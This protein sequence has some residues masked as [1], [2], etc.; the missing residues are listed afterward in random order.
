MLCKG[1]FPLK[2]GLCQYSVLHFNISKPKD[3]LFTV[4]CLIE[5]TPCDLTYPAHL[6]I[7][8]QK[9]DSDKNN[10]RSNFQKCDK[11]RGI[12]FSRPDERAADPVVKSC[13]LETGSW[14]RRRLQTSKNGPRRRT[15]GRSR[16]GQR[17]LAPRALRVLRQP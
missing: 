8:W 10:A 4:E 6:F 3:L 1:S 13:S 2:A 15:R 11:I 9:L 12:A 14:K 16:R 17:R 5:S 7:W